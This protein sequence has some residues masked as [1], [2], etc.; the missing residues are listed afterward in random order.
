MLLYNLQVCPMNVF[1]LL[2]LDFVI[3]RFF[4]KLFKINAID[5]VKVCQD[6]FDFVSIVL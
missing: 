5:P 1:D 4:M 6:Y 2:S 3:N